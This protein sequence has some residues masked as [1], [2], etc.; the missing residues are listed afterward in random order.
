MPRQGQIDPI[1][2]GKLQHRT[3]VQKR[4]GEVHRGIAAPRFNQYTRRPHNE[5]GANFGD[6]L[7]QSQACVVLGTQAG[8]APVCRINAK[9]GI[10]ANKIGL[11]NRRKPNTASLE[12]R[13][14]ALTH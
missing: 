9:N 6:Q 14:I 2:P 3:A 1:L 5:F 7:A 13:N 4:V 8:K 10:I 11:V 12:L